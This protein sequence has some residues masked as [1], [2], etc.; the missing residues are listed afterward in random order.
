MTMPTPRHASSLTDS[1]A[2]S[3]I[4]LRPV[5]DGD[6]PLLYHLSTDPASG[7]RWRFS[8]VVPPFEH[9]RNQL[10]EGVLVQFVAV[11]RPTQEAIGWVV[12]L[13]P[14]QHSGHAGVGVTMLPE[15]RHN[16]TGLE[17]TALLIDYCFRVWRFRKIYLE[18][19][20]FSFATFAHLGTSAFEVEGVLRDHHY[21]DG[22]YWHQYIIAIYRE[23][24][25]EFGRPLLRRLGDA[26]K[27]EVGS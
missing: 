8:G 23:A 6:L 9:F 14:D 27:A 2:T 13:N 12:A 21:Y 1:M 11:H 5:N 16:G 10:W 17:A 25:T 18:S 26:E 4:L 3:R 7:Y 19:V 20:E 15:H 22:T 24:W